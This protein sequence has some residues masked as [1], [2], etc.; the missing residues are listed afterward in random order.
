MAP[1]R[2]AAFVTRGISDSKVGYSTEAPEHSV[3]TLEVRSSTPNGA[4]SYIP[5]RQELAEFAR[6][7]LPSAT[8]AVVGS[9]ITTTGPQAPRLASPSRRQRV[10]PA[11]QTIQPP[12]EHGDGLFSGSQLGEAFMNSGFSTPHNAN[13]AVEVDR[14]PDAKAANRRSN[15]EPALPATA[16]HGDAD[17]NSHKFHVGENGRLSVV[18]GRFRPQPTFLNDGFYDEGR[19][20]T[21]DRG[22]KNYPRERIPLETES[23]ARLPVRAAV[24]RDQKHGTH[25]TVAQI[26]EEVREG[27]Q[28]DGNGEWQ[29]AADE[30]RIS[31]SVLLED[32]DDELEAYVELDHRRRALRDAGSGGAGKATSGV[33]Q[34]EMTR[35]Q[36]TNG[37]KRRHVTLDYDDNV[38]A[39]MT[40]KDLQEE[41]FDLSPTGG[42]VNGDGGSSAPAMLKQRLDQYQ[43]KDEAGQR[44]L[45]TKMSVEEWEEAGDWFV[46]Q[47]AD[48]MT[49]LKEARREKRRKMHEFEAEAAEREEA[50]RTQTEMIDEKLIKMKQDG[51][52]VVGK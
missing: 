44:A 42:V 24:S 48:I 36:G 2:M 27:I 33:G 26:K 6:I 34:P 18:P 4:A 3:P 10:S 9:T 30:E 1:G 28:V 12:S 22:P 35:R 41:P 16:Y 8:R 19:Y 31:D 17:L 52:R 46:D 21:T 14:T 40:F 13:N 11:K 32:S 23:Q 39:S 5:T 7:P 45:F 49:R 15:R 38:L 47:F 25:T 20:R 43:Q 50:V 37:P 51:Q 29:D